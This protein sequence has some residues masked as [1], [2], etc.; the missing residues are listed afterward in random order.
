MLKGKIILFLSPRFFG[1]EDKIRVALE[2]AGA[3]VFHEYG[4]VTPKWYKYLLY[5]PSSFLEKKKRTYYEDLNTKHK[6]KKID[7]LFVIEGL[8]VTPDFVRSFKNIHP[9]ST[10]ICYNWDS[11]RYAN[12]MNIVGVFDKNYTFDYKDSEQY[13]F[14]FIPTF[15]CPEFLELVDKKS[16]IKYDMLF[17]GSFKSNR[18]DYINSIVSKYGNTLRIKVMLY[19]SPLR[20]F[21]EKMKLHHI[22]R[23]MVIFKPLSYGEYIDYLSKTRSVLDYTADVQTGLPLRVYE[24]L[25]AQRKLITNNPEAIKEFG[26]G[27]NIIVY[28]PEVDLVSFINQE[29]EYI[30]ISNYSI[31]N[32]VKRIFS[33]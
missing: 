24:S 13:G 7:Y 10:T 4:Y 23:S 11:M 14:D 9:E 12:Y 25:A 29:T 21:V 17:I 33:F 31:Q 26:E 27:F 5:T 1:Y 3:V 30:D 28:T 8:R 6:N 32:F 20:F 2:E 16:D 15:Y 18:V 22:K 19:M